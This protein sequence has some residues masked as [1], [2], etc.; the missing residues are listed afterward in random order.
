MGGQIPL[1]RLWLP[2]QAQEAMRR[3]AE[4]CRPEECCGLL[5]GEPSGRVRFVYPLTNIRRSPTAFTIDPVEHFRAWQHATRQGWDLIGAFHSHPGGPRY[6]SATDLALAAEPDWAWVIVTGD[7]VDAFTIR[8][9]K[10]RPLPID[11]PGR[12]PVTD[13]RQA[14]S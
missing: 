6:P 9:R 3:H 12:S 14:G 10:A 1:T 11:Q 13:A 8:E 4:A 2:E 5:A 7:S